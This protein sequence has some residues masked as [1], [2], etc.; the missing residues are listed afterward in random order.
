MLLD[1][2]PSWLKTVLYAL[3]LSTGFEI[4]Y[5]LRGH[6]ILKQKTKGEKEEIEAVFFPDSTVACDA[7]FSYGCTD[8]S[9]WLSHKETSVMRVAHF[10]E[11]VE[12]TLDVCVYCI[13]SQK[14]VDS[15]LKCHS[16]GIIVQVLTDQ[17]Q[18][19]EQGTQIARL[20]AAG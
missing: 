3:T 20:R 13:A 7:H 6:H 14:L 18:A 5:Y 11:S 8:K 12:K 16:Q 10:L 4:I 1:G 15:I 2:I 19:S 17:A 9:C